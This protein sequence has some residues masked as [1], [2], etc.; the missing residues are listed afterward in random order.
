ML[1]KNVIL[2]VILVEN[3]LSQ[4]FYEEPFPLYFGP[5]KAYL[6]LVNPCDLKLDRQTCY[7]K[8]IQL[9]IEDLCQIVED[10]VEFLKMSVLLI[11]IRCEHVL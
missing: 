11:I 5:L 10:F 4:T 6:G 7:S 9:F 1:T 8:L 2:F 3:P